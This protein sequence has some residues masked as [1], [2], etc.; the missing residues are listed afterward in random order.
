M[1]HLSIPP[2]TVPAAESYQLGSAH[3][4]AGSVIGV[5]PLRLRLDGERWMPVM[6][7]LHYTRVP[8]VSWREELLRMKAGGIDCVATYVFWIHHE[9]TEG[10]FN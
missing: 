8:A 3:N 5:D 1:L 10:A 9:E 2:A 6:G 7:E 4:P